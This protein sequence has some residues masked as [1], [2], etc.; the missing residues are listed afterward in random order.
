MAL[1]ETLMIAAG[2][3]IVLAVAL[4]V[5]FLIGAAFQAGRDAAYQRRIGDGR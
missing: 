5:V 2:L 3:L 1:A 4:F